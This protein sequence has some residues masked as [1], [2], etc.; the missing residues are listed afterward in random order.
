MYVYRIVVTAT[1]YGSERDRDK[2][3]LHMEANEW[4]EKKQK[5]K[6]TQIT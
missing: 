6:H 5:N 1:V 2:D 3:N 4:Y